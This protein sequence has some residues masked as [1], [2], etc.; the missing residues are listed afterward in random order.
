MALD[1]LLSDRVFLAFPRYLC[2]YLATRK[3]ASCFYYIHFV[4]IS[5]R[6][7]PFE[8]I[9]SPSASLLLIGDYSALF[10]S[11]PRAKFYAS[12]LHSTR[13][14]PTSSLSKGTMVSTNGTVST[15]TRYI[16]RFSPDASLVWTSFCISA[17]SSKAPR[18]HER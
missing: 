16:A 11:S 8:C 10:P 7:D 3:I 5:Q 15:E 14:T 13:P 2:L 4:L 6:S 9:G 1:S 17:G 12:T 18:R